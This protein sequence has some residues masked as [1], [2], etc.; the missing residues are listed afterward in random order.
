MV[1]SS[2]FGGCP[3]ESGKPIHRSKDH[4]TNNAEIAA[5]AAP[6]PMLVISDGKDWTQNVPTIEF[7]F[8][9]K[10]Y[11]LYNAESN[12]ENVHLAA[13]GHDYGPSKRQAMYRFMARHLKLDHSAGITDENGV[14]IELEAAMRVF[15]PDSLPQGTCRSTSE[16]E[17]ALTNAQKK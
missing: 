16:I 10:I 2:M 15:T 5:M 11:R 8:L 13:E 12:V 4:F 1:S 9:Q 3:C 7:P 6:R 14:A 17:A